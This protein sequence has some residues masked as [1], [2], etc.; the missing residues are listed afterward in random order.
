MAS[1]GE[2]AEA[3]DALRSA[4]CRELVLLHC[5]SGYPTPPTEANLATIPHLSQMLGVPVGLSD[6]TLDTAV[7]V[8]AVALGAVAIEKHFTL[9]RA[10][11]GPDAAFSLEPEEFARLVS[12]TRTAWQQQGP[13]TAAI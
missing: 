2:M 3:V 13:A 4:G 9:R 5:I 1:V 10:D 11:G 6:H 8:A 12:S 7:A